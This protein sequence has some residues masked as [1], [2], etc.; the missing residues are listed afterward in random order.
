VN[1]D[2][3]KEMAEEYLKANGWNEWA[4]YVLKTLEELKQQSSFQ[5]GKIDVNRQE[6]ISAVNSL[7]LSITKEMAELTTGITV[8]KKQMAWRSVVWSSIIPAITAIVIA[9]LK[10]LG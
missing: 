4:K 6:F 3:L 9:A 7:E 10:V 2:A 1:K 5:E 8:L